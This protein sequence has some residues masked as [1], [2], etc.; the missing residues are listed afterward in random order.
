MA[1]F[2]S[3]A[4]FSGT[5]MCLVLYN[6]NTYAGSLLAEITPTSVQVYHSPAIYREKGGKKIHCQNLLI[7]KKGTINLKC[8]SSFPGLPPPKKI[9]KLYD[10]KASSCKEEISEPE[11]PKFSDSPQQ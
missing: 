10:H 3:V 8:E 6:L 9:L 11:N 7:K 4:D 2:D 1:I 5:I